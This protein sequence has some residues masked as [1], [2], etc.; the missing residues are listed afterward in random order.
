MKKLIITSFLVLTAFF[1]KSQTY[2]AIPTEL[3]NIWNTSRSS[4][5][6]NQDASSITSVYGTPDY[7][8]SEYWEMSDRTVQKYHY[9]G[10]VFYLHNNILVMMELNTPDYYIGK[11]DRA[12][13]V[14]ENISSLASFYP[15]SYNNRKS[16][17]MVLLVQ[18]S[19]TDPMS[20]S[21][22]IVVKFNSSGI[23][24]QVDLVIE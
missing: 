18:F 12:I 19:S 3:I 9:N 11:I 10:N 24:T 14:G 6:L 21:E 8:T 1:C 20:V 16:D 2:D 7:I 13:R 23:I 5:T 22:Y 4:L 17:Y 15:N